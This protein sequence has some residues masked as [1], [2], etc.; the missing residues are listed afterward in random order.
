MEVG[1]IGGGIGGL[2]TAWALH[3][4][5]IAV[6][7]FEKAPALRGLGAGLTLQPNAVLAL[8]ALGL[9]AAVSAV[10]QPLGR[11]RIRDYRDRTLAQTDLDSLGREI[12]A[13]AWAVHRADLHEVLLA[14]VPADSLGLGRALT[15]LSVEVE[16][17]E[18]AFAD[19]GVEHMPWLIGADGV[20][21]AVRRA[22]GLDPGPRYSGYTCWRGVVE[23]DMPVDETTETWGPAG[24]FGIVPLTAG[25]V[26]WF[27]TRN[28]LAQDPVMGAWQVADLRRNFAHYPTDVQQVLEATPEEALLW[29]DIGDFTPLPAFH[30]GRALLLGDAAHA[31]TPNM[32]Q[33]A[34]MAIED[35]AVVGNLVRQQGLS[36]ETWARFSALRG[37]RTRAIVNRSYQLGRMA[38]WSDPFR[39]RLRDGLM[40]LVP[41]RLTQ[42]QMRALYQV[43]LATP[44][45]RSVP[46]AR[47]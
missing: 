40:R 28:A 42:R 26:Y 45:R 12:G 21:S 18:V 34:C 47:G 36:E 37:P 39:S 20:G 16:R 6:R 32:G 17:V 33:G 27:A 13:P 8:R 44:D 43:D 7:V 41:A 1:I 9:E 46:S 4:Q 30:R 38:Q 19:G 23:V 24:R 10:A 35:A 14:Q 5:G 2:C 31:T 3:Q 25:R 11:M 22:L 29:H 15:G